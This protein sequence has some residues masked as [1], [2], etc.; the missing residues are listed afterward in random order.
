MRA[1]FLSIGIVT[2]GFFSFPQAV[3]AANSWG[4]CVKTV[5]GVEVATL[6]CFEEVFK[7]ILLFSSGIALLAFFI[8]LVIA[9][10]KLLTSGGNPKATESARNTMTYAFIGITVFVGAFIIIRLISVFTG[11]DLTHFAIPTPGP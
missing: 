2:G 5:N 4:D 11:V 7:R 10:L 9:A 1:S 8:M 3:Y 6:Q